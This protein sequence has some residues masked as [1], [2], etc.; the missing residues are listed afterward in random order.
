MSII[1][2]IIFDLGG[3]ILNI[4]YQ[5]TIKAFN[6]LGFNNFE[7]FY[8]QKKQLRVFDDFETG[9][10]EGMASGCAIISE[11]LNSITL[12]EL[13]LSDVI[14]QV[15]NPESLY[16]AL[17]EF[18]SNPMLLKEYQ[19]KSQLAIEKHTWHSRIN[20]FTKKFNEFV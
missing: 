11:K 2:H 5:L 18:K 1:K 14:Y 10:F 13:N 12:K 3:V 17:K 4:D 16:I 9:I 20:S 7:S 19:T 8:T 15:D 6:S